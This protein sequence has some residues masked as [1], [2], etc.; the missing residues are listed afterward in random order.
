MTREG[1]GGWGVRRK[2]E[3]E[4]ERGRNVKMEVVVDEP[5]KSLGAEVFKTA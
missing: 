4:R 3:R 1:V 5:S 2:R